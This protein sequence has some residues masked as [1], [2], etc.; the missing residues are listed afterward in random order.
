MKKIKLLIVSLSLITLLCTA[1]LTPPNIIGS[2]ETYDLGYRFA[3][4]LY[5]DSTF[6][7]P[8]LI[9]IVGTPT[10][11]I[12]KWTVV[13]DTLIM[14]DSLSPDRYGKEYMTKFDTMIISERIDS[15]IYAVM[16]LEER[17]PTIM[18]YKIINSDTLITED[19]NIYVRI[20]TLILPKIFYEH[21]LMPKNEQT[22]PGE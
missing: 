10:I 8:H 20:D 19:K 13:D 6:M 5:A 18:K 9:E 4:T 12:G 2:Y 15:L 14:R 21:P 22:I 17:N 3:F 11:A 16:E 1:F 7:R